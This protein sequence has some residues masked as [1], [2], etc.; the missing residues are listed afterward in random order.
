M[1]ANP[2]NTLLSPDNHSLLMNVRL[3]ALKSG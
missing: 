1:P 3:Q 2:A